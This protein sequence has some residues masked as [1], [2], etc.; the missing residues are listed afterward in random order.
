MTSTILET[1][2][3]EVRPRQ[4]R[5]GLLTHL[6]CRREGPT[7]ARQGGG[8]LCLPRKRLC[9]KGGPIFVGRTR[10]PPDLAFRLEEG[11]TLSDERG[12]CAGDFWKNT[13]QVQPGKGKEGRPQSLSTPHTERENRDSEIRAGGGNSVVGSKERRAPTLRGHAD[14]GLQRQRGV[15]ADPASF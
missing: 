10:Q 5:G 7:F 14:K 12:L 4:R 2:A 6:A 1:R 8:T 11:G 15:H 13:V 9:K 3:L